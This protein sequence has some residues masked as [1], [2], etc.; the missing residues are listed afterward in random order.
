MS[1]TASTDSQSNTRVPARKR[2]TDR[3][4]PFFGPLPRQP[5]HVG[6]IVPRPAPWLFS[7]GSGT[8]SHFSTVITMFVASGILALVLLSIPSRPAQAIIVTPKYYPPA[9]NNINNLTAVLGGSGAPGIFTS[10]STP[11]RDYGMYNWCN[12]PHVRKREYQYVHP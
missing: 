7:L 9:S 10:S 1:S 4:K 8:F 2:D 6:Q 12:M 5:D 3:K 11:D